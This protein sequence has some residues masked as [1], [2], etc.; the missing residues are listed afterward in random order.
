MNRIGPHGQHAVCER[1]STYQSQFQFQHTTYEP[2]HE[3]T[4]YSHEPLSTTPSRSY[5]RLTLNPQHRPHNLYPPPLPQLH[6]PHPD[7]LGNLRPPAT[8][9]K[10]SNNALQGPLLRPTVRLLRI[11]PSRS[12]SATRAESTYD[13]VQCGEGWG[14]VRWT[15]ESER[16]D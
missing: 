3:S 10:T 5:P 1:V 2:I 16:E 6:N 14:T 7:K 15:T 9:N 13:S 8:N 4:T 11:Y 12:T